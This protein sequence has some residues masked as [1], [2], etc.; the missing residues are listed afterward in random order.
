MGMDSV[1]PWLT[2]VGIAGDVR[3]RGLTGDVAPAVYVSYLQN[4]ERT[5]Y[6]VTTVVRAAADADAAATVTALRQTLAAL[7]PNV[8]AEFSTMEA[9]VGTSVAD[10]RF[11]MLVL[12]SFGAIALLL[13]AIGVYGVLAYAVV[14]RTQEIGIRMALGADARSVVGL[15]LKGALGSVLTGIVIGLAA[16]AALTRMLQSMLFEV[17]PTDPL[18]LAVALALVAGVAWLAGFLPAR[19]ATRIDPLVAMRVE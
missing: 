2:I 10:R 4:P 9:Q 15:V 17:R 11:T 3:Y 13:A 16:V 19:R 14:Q 6:F 5:T 1:N 7:D 18:T 12:A 8:P